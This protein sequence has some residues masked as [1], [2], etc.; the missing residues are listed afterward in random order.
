VKQQVEEVIG[1]DAT[2]A[3]EISAKTGMGIEDVLE[4]IVQQLP[5]P[6]EGDRNAP[7]K[8][9]LVDSW[10]DSY[11]G[12]IVLVRVIDGV[13]KKGQTI[14]MMGTGAKY[15]VERTGVFT[16]KMLQ[17]DELGPGEL[18]FITASI[19]EVADTRVGD[20]ITEER[21]PTQD[22]LPGF[23]PAQPVVF[24]GLFP[25]DAADFEDLRAAMGKLRLNDASFSYEMETSAA[26]GF[27][28]RCGFLGLLHLEIIQERLE[29]EFNL[30]LITTAPSVVYRL[31]MTDGTEKELHNPA[32]MPD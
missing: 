24:C 1:I 3:V 10:Y 32:D 23:K 21:R 22:M 17:V 2:D 11:L 12:V 7:L 27:G 30:D 15:P 14:R 18:G 26:L 16:P 19:K 31:Q 8:A 29:R 4:A 6:Q 5:A 13:L 25:V 28:F 20:T 9:M